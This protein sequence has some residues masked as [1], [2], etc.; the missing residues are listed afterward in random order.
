MR[1]ARKKAMQF[2]RISI[3]QGSEFLKKLWCCVG[4]EVKRKNLNADKI[5]GLEPLNALHTPLQMLSIA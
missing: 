4:G 1:D 5:T 2:K 3:K